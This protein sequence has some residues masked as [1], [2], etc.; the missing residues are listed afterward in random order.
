MQLLLINYFS[1]DL[2]KTQLKTKILNKIA[3][4]A[5]SLKNA[6]EKTQ[7]NNVTQFFDLNSSDLKQRFSISKICI[8]FSHYF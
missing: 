1:A 2:F 5:Q 6:I 3:D 7:T 8:I 4:E